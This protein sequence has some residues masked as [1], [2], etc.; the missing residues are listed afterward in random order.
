MISLQGTGGLAFADDPAEVAVDVNA[1]IDEALACVDCEEL[2]VVEVA[3][4]EAGGS[5]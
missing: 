3:G 4:V 5:P 2:V 1:L